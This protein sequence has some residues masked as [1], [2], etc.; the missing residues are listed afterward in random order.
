MPVNIY[1]TNII[2]PM[3]V[4]EGG[5]YFTFVRALCSYVQNEGITVWTN[6]NSNFS[7]SSD[8]VSVQKIFKRRIRRFQMFFL[9][10]KLFASNEKIFIP[11]AGTTE[12]FLAGL[13]S[14]GPIPKDK[15]YLYFH[16]VKERRKKL[17]IYRILTKNHPNIIAIAPTDSVVRFLE[18]CGFKNILKIPYP[19]AVRSEYLPR[20][21]PV[22]KYLLFA[23]STRYDKGIKE[24]VDLVEYISNKKE[25]IKF[26]IQLMENYETYPDDTRPFITKL[27]S[28]NYPGLV[29]KPYGN[30][31]DEYISLFQNSIC[32]QLYDQLAFKDRI[33][34]VTLDALLSGCPVVTLPGTW[35]AKMID[36]FNAGIVVS[37][38]SP[39]HVYA[40]VKKIIGNYPEY[41]KN[42]YLGGNTLSSE[43]SAQKLLEVIT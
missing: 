1:R 37:D 30:S 21:K 24:V 17:W 12:A 8:S 7:S 36:R 14:K 33:S 28:L 27:I 4:T 29:I 31:F 26:C 41:S 39:E 11:T 15:V 42:A 40:A 6:S 5:H 38:S 23:G 13:A 20:S 35:I 25:N 34:G 43:N 22:F 18:E 19:V 32:L 3:L 16:Y 9:L 10:R 2:E